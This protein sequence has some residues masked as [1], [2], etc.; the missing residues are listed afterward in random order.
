MNRTQSE[1]QDWIIWA[2]LL[3]PVVWAAVVAAQTYTGNL[4][5]WMD[6]LEAS[7]HGDA[8][9]AQMDTGHLA[10]RG[11]IRRRIRVLCALSLRNTP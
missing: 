11:H 10:F 9:P 1:K 8:T 4:L 2:L 3:L 7:G 6:A 5:T